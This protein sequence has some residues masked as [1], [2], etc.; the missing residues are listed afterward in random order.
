M[1]LELPAAWRKRFDL[2]EIGFVFLMVPLVVSTMDHAPHLGAVVLLWLGSA[3]LVRRIPD[4]S[5][6]LLSDWESFRL[7]WA[8]L[9]ILGVAG[10]GALFETGHAIGSMVLLVLHAV[11]FSLPLCL[12]AFRYAPRRFAG[13]DWLPAW[14]LGSLSAVLFAGLHLGTGSWKAAGFA[15]LL[16]LA[17]RSMPLSIATL[18]HAAGWA[19]G[20]RWGLW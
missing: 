7:P 19:A 5:R 16:G 6:D 15:F 3:F 8:P 4:L 9:W 14:S 1:I 10:I 11:L 20:S 2:F 12:L 18:L 17:G 13:S